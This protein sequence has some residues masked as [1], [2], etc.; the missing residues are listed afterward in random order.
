MKTPH[1]LL[2]TLICLLLKSCSS[3]NLIEQIDPENK[4]VPVAIPTAGNEE[5]YEYKGAFY[6]PVT[7]AL[8]KEDMP[9]I[10]SGCSYSSMFYHRYPNY[11][12]D[13]E[14]KEVYLFRL[15]DEELFVHVKKNASSGN[16][17]ATNAPSF[18]SEKEFPFAQAKRHRQKDIAGHIAK[19]NNTG[20]EAV[21]RG[22][23]PVNSPYPISVLPVEPGTRSWGNRLAYALLWIPDTAGNLLLK[24]TE[25]VLMTAGT[26]VVAVPLGI[27]YLCGERLP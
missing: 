8:A 6:L 19:P 7:V 21:H 4:R 10:T 14:S 24:G 3:F 2:L 27:L 13:E 17:N 16:Q 11:A 18:Y 23:N 26:A 1:Y 9:L 25:S 22:R 15:T 5:V 20:W 12:L